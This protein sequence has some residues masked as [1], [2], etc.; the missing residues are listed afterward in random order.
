MTI[1]FSAMNNNIVIVNKQTTQNKHLSLFIEISYKIYEFNVIKVSTNIY[2]I[3]IYIFNVSY[4]NFYKGKKR[5][6]LLFLASF[7]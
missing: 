3:Y 6:L 7:Y 2:N 1:N 5:K 4:F